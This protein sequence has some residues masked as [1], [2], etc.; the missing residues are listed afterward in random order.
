MHGTKNN[1]PIFKA[2]DVSVEELSEKPDGKTFN[3]ENDTMGM[4][5]DIND[6]GD[7]ESVMKE[8]PVEVLPAEDVQL[9]HQ[10]LKNT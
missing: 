9:F 2:V 1:V 8:M 7:K 6:S 5:K 10:P 3:K 4:D